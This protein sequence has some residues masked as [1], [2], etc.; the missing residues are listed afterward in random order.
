MKTK[1]SIGI[2]IGLSLLILS[3]LAHS[4]V[5]VQAYCQK[6]ITI[7]EFD[8]AT[9]AVIR[10]F[11]A[12]LGYHNSN[13]FDLAKKEFDSVLFTDV[14]TYYREQFDSIWD[15]R[16]SSPYAIYDKEETDSLKDFIA[17]SY[18]NSLN[19]IFWKEFNE[20]YQY[21]QHTNVYDDTIYTPKATSLVS[22]KEKSKNLHE[23][24]SA[25]LSLNSQLA[26]PYFYRAEL[27]R[28]EK[29]YRMAYQM[30]HTA[31]KYIETQRD[32]YKEIYDDFIPSGA[33]IPLASIYDDKLVFTLQSQNDFI[34]NYAYIVS[35]IFQYNLHD[36]ESF[37][38]FGKAYL[39]EVTLPYDA[40]LDELEEIIWM[41]IFRTSMNLNISTFQLCKQYFERH[42]KLQAEKKNI[43][44][45]TN[46]TKPAITKP[47]S[48]F[49]PKSYYSDQVVI[50]R[51]IPESHEKE[52][53]WLYDNYC[54]L[55]DEVN[56]RNQNQNDKIYYSTWMK[57]KWQ[58]MRNEMPYRRLVNN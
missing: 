35:E 50:P 5:T 52:L 28:L 33:I 25:T 29:N 32:F 48:I 37:S 13:H 47:D 46:D 7:S 39:T 21:Q 16:F 23:L 22:F 6:A 3:S 57:E 18:N 51:Q 20:L 8:S 14:G 40:F 53:R 31:F 15:L 26:E 10:R 45:T 56:K 41:E 42:N 27:F 24:I 38:T 9:S 19:R 2:I 4:Q 58:M 44:E 34:H 49:K 17:F 30:Y 36:K 11:N 43:V 12:A 55:R 54:E 1:N